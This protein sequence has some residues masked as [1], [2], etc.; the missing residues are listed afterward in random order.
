MPTLAIAFSQTNIED[1]SGP[2]ADDTILFEGA[3]EPSRGQA[4]FLVFCTFIGL[5]SFALVMSILYQDIGDKWYLITLLSPFAGVYYWGNAARKEEVEKPNLDLYLELYV[6]KIPEDMT[7]QIVLSI[8]RKKK[9]VDNKL[10]CTPRPL[11]LWISQAEVKMLTSDDDMET[12]ITVQGPEEVVE[13]F[14]RELRLAEKGK[15]YVKG[16]LEN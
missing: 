1:L 13:T 6:L 12:E 4:A 8:F 16:I 15:V 3:T 9:K 11:I 14:R 2:D 5:G 7:G 10:P